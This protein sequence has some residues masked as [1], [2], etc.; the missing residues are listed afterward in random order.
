VKLPP[1]FSLRQFDTHRLIPSKYL[2]GG[3]SVLT[4]IA[5]DKAHL[6]VIFDLDNATNDRLQAEND[7]LPGIGIHE[8]VFAVPNYRIINAAFTHAHPRGSRFNG[9][10]RGAWYAGFELQTA[11]Q[12]VAWHKSVE[13]AEIDYWNDSITY[14]DFL[15]DFDGAFHDIRGSAGYEACLAPDSYVAAQGLAAELLNAGSVGLVYPSVRYEGGTCIA[16]FRPAIVGNVRRD[17]RYRFTW[18]G[19]T[20]PK[21][22]VE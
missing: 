1:V 6:D 12:E 10:D 9:P 3:D 15:A 2:P 17:A 14:D 21:I 7:L 22:Q 5:D 20:A 11:Q 8:L 16:C 19:T 4:S 13:Y 18:I